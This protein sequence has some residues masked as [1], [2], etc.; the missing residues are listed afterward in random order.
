MPED[1]TFRQAIVNDLIAPKIP[2]GIAW[3]STVAILMATPPSVQLL[4]SGSLFEIAGERF[5]VTAAHVIGA[6]SSCGA[7][8]GISS[9]DASLTATPGQWMATSPRSDGVDPYDVAVYRLPERAVER[10]SDKHFLRREDADFQDQSTTG[11]FALFGF[12]GLWT[13]PSSA[14]REPVRSKGFE[15]VAYAF[16]ADKDQFGGFDSRHHLLLDAT[17][18]QATMPDGSP[19]TLRHRNGRFA[20]FPLDLGGISGCPVWVIGDLRAPIEKWGPPRL[21][22]V[23]THVY[24][25]C[26]AIRAT[27]WAAVTTLIASAYPSLRPALELITE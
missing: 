9:S 6:A 19:A 20:S 18:K 26:A 4:G 7:T 16:S 15:Y 22:G 14:Q 25:E 5:V 27:R 8:I 10:L 2:V 1:S 12:P 24:R 23:Q 21:V 3:P 11:V 17:A 13:M